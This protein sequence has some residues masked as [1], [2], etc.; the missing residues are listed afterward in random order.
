MDA[1]V[2]GI[3][4]GASLTKI[5]VAQDGDVAHELHPSTDAPALFGRIAAL[6]PGRVGLTG[7]GAARWADA[8]SCPIVRVNEF[9]AWGSGASALLREQD[10]LGSDPYLI[11]SVGTGTSILHAD[12]MSVNRVGGTAL[13][14]G[15]IVGLGGLLLGGIEFDELAALAQQGNRR[16]VDLIV[17]DIYSPGEIA[18]TGDITAASFGKPDVH[19]KK[20]APADLADAVMGLVG[21]NVALICNGFAAAQGIRRVVFA[22][23]TL[24]NN[25]ALNDTLRVV[26]L[27]YGR[28]P[29]VLDS[30]EFAGARGALEIA[31]I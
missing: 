21:E 28:E 13:G 6:E 3:D 11:V 15:T 23:S 27:A 26:S 2:I 30:V 10:A 18:L 22:G 8:L 16:N 29:L 12:G 4:A 19:E 7:A 9:A 24:R 14:G 1:P 20:P 5:A 17:S 31:G 25:P